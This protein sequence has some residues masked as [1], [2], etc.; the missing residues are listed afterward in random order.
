MQIALVTTVDYTVKHCVFKGYKTVENTWP[1]SG[2]IIAQN[3]AY[4]SYRWDVNFGTSKKI[5][6]MTGN[7]VSSNIFEACLALASA[8]TYIDNANDFTLDDWQ[9]YT[10]GYY[11]Y[12]YATN[13]SG[14]I[15]GLDSSRAS[16]YIYFNGILDGT[17]SWIK[18]INSL[19]VDSGRT[20]EIAPAA[21]LVI[22]RDKGLSIGGK[23]IVN[24]T[25][26]GIDS[27]SMLYTISGASV[28]GLS[29]IISGNDYFWNGSSWQ[30]SI[31]TT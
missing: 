14:V 7:G 3:L 17:E 22:P 2:V 6:S 11:D 23:L 28:S 5:I 12:V 16:G 15:N 1:S 4:E 10:E 24:G 25:L 13:I 26:T 20:L 31:P 30:I 19:A 27:T 9:N 29:G 21:K 8:N 18:D